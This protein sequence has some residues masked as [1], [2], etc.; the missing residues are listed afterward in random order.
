MTTSDP[1][2]DSGAPTMGTQRWARLLPIVFI[3]YSLAYL[4][5]SNFSIG[6]AGGMSEELQITPAV[7]ALIGAAFFLGYFVFQIPGA[8]YAERRSVR[9]LIFWSLLAWGVLA[10]V[11]GLLSSA[12]ALIAVRFLIGVVEAAVLPAMVIFLS[13]WFTSRERG[14]ANTFL[15]LGNPVTVLWLTVVSGF[16]IEATDWRWMFIIEGL[17]AV[18]WAFVFRAMVSDRP[19]QAKWLNTPERDAVVA[20]LE[21]EQ[22]GLTPVKGY[23]EAFRSRNVVL[24]SLQY[25]LWSVGVY[26]FVFWLPS[27][28]KAASGEGIGMSGLISA[29]PYV[30]AVVLMIL[31]SRSSDRAGTRGRYVWPWLLLGAVAFYGSYLLGPDQ[32]WLAFILLTVAGGA[33]YAP[34]GPYFAQIP[35]FLPNNVAGAA[36]ALINSFGALGGFAGSYLVGWLNGSTG[37]TD[38][39]FLLM[40]GCLAAAAAI[41]LLVRAPAATAPVE[42]PVETA[43][44]TGR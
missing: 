26:G 43:A 18:A 32:F 20:E 33:M 2:A 28:V 34:Y 36:I 5:R 13:H 3:T 23:G 17:P 19:E 29:I 25:F 38:A 31:N 14:R 30:L 7:S 1:R 10:S 24:L 41:M 6:I 42:A 11:Q 21:K 9:S 16:L 12:T 39:S 8:I 35:E 15:I 4:D 22:R 44:E 40:A 27:I 37:S